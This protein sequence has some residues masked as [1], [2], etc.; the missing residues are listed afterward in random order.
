MGS[1]P[2]NWAIRFVLEIAALIAMG[3]WAWQQGE[4]A[5]RYVF[6]ALVPLVA[7][8]LWGVFAV[9]GD[10]SRS[11]SA[12]VA[13]SGAL[14]LGIEAAFFAFAVWALYQ[15]GS[16]ALSATMA[17]ALAVHYAVSYDRVAW[18]LRA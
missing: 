14:R 12:P 6:G 17:T 11:G 7:A 13:V 4:G 18:L 1:H 16:T 9:P 10:P 5:T 2:A 15:L 3:F 8:T